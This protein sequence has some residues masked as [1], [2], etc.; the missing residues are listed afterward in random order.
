MYCECTEGTGKKPTEEKTM[1]GPTE[2]RDAPSSE[3]SGRAETTVG[4]DHPI[5]RLT[6]EETAH[7]RKLCTSRVTAVAW[8]VIAK[9]VDA[10]ERDLARAERWRTSDEL[11][12]DEP[13]QDGWWV[14]VVPGETKPRLVY[15]DA[16]TTY[17]IL[18]GAQWFGPFG[19]LPARSEERRAR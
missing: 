12:E 18:P 14:H 10:A 4:A 9:L 8:D 2:V 16:G 6:R 5:E 17:A 11:A 13:D 19:A 3:Q 1:A 7:L 15:I